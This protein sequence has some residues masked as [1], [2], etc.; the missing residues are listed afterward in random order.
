[1]ITM[2]RGITCQQNL[3]DV[4]ICVAVFRAVNND[5]DDLIP[6]I[7]EFNAVPAKVTPG[8]VFHLG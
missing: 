4:E 1:M 5:I 3:M 8:G 6:I 7:P 2:D